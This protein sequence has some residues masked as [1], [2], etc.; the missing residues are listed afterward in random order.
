[1]AK[2]SLL[3]CIF[4][5]SFDSKLLMP[6]SVGNL[7]TERSII[8]RR[9]LKFGVDYPKIFRLSLRKTKLASMKKCRISF[10][11]NEHNSLIYLN[12]NNKE[13]NKGGIAKALKK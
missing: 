5:A 4:A 7:S 3:Y 13:S 6:D 2:I 9:V 8:F 12:L 10:I 1:M 11:E